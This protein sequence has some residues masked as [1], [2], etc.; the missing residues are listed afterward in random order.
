ML[1]HP[2]SLPEPDLNQIVF[3]KLFKFMPVT[4]GTDFYNRSIMLAGTVFISYSTLRAV[5]DYLYLI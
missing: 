2:Y 1:I 5:F 4:V 3:I